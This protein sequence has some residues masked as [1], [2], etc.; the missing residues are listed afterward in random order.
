MS[1]LMDEYIK[2][3]VWNKGRVVP[4]LE[5]DQWRHDAYGD[6]IRYTDYGNRLSEYGWE[7]DHI[8]PQSLGG[9]DELYNLQ[10]LHWRNNVQKGGQALTWF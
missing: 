10:P 1:N 2:W 6:L 7:M 3:M 4:F 9:A 5:P 8:Y